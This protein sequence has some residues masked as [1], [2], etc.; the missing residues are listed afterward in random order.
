MCTPQRGSRAPSW[1]DRTSV[2]IVCLVC[3]CGC[4]FVSHHLISLIYLVGFNS[5]LPLRLLLVDLSSFI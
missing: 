1:C 5:T 3:F 4:D 2:K